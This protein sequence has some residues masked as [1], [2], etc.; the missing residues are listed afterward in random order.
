MIYYLLC[1]YVT[2]KVFINLERKDLNVV[3]AR[4]FCYYK[5]YF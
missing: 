3:L 5:L 2:N 1:K 4:Y